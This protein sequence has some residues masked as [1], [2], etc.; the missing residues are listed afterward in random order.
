MAQFNRGD[1]VQHPVFGVGQ[2]RTDEGTTVIIRFQHGIEECVKDDL[3]LIHTPRQALSHSQWHAPFDVITRIQ[4]NA[5]QS[6]NDS[7][8]VFS[9][10]RVALLPHQLWVCR[11]VVETWPTRWMVADDVGL[12]KTIEGGLILSSL[13]ARNIVKRALIIAPASLVT[14]WQIRLRTMFDLRFADYI[15]ASDVPEKEFWDTHNFVV[16]SLE[17]LRLN[18][19]DRWNR[20]L[21]SDPWDLIILDEAHHIGADERNGPT[22][23]YELIQQMVE[24]KRVTSMVFFTGTPHRGK[25]FNFL[26]LMRLLDDRFDPQISFRQQLKYLPSVMIRNNKQNVTDLKGNLLFKPPLVISDTYTYSESEK[27]F[28]QKLTEFIVTG[29]AYASS[30]NPSESQVVILV[31]ITMQKLASSSLAAI[32]RA[33]KGRLGRINDNKG[34]HQILSKQLAEYQKYQEGGDLDEANRLEEELA[35][36]SAQIQ[37]MEDESPRLR[38]LISAAEAVEDET[39][40]KQIIYLVKNRYPDRAILFFTEY[41][42]T[43]SRLMSYLIEQFGENCVTFINGEDRAEDVINSKKQ[44]VVLNEIRET[45]AEKFQSGKVRFL[46]STEAGGEGIDLQENCHTLIH[47]DLPWNPMRLH[48]RV[49]RLNR[50]GQK[51]QVEVL[52]IRNLETV[53]AAIWDKLNSKLGEIKLALNHVMDEPED[54]LQLVLGM[55]SSHLFNEIYSEAASVEQ[56]KLSNWFNQKTAHFGGRDA[57]DTVRDLVGSTSR[58]DFQEIS[59]QL[60]HVDLPNL[61]S[62]FTTMLQLNGRRYREESGEF[63]FKTPENWLD[64]PAIRQNY[65]NMVF[66]REIR[67]KNAAQRILGVGQ[68]VFQKALDQAK[69]SEASL[70][71]LPS[72]ILPTPVFVFRI[73][74]RVTGSGGIVRSVIAA[75]EVEYAE[76]KSFQLLSDWKL[77]LLLNDLI[78][79]KKIKRSEVSFRP[80]NTDEVEKKLNQ[81][82]AEMITQL[83]QLN[84]PFKVPEVEEFAILWPEG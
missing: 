30:L 84:L 67:G 55:T 66:T 54:L 28:Y 53:E 73:Y 13:I 14:Q 81:A 8:G 7:W 71:M 74:D 82:Q 61:V 16:G 57:I 75:L 20:L 38:E 9:L 46:V 22:L 63:S 18:N 36:L 17:T 1:Q 6:I 78:D 39:K 4:A 45:A 21:E 32:L 25:N 31:L 10:S 2:V 27:N 15:S 83:H 26:S 58:F 72:Q 68:K 70:V 42:A 65:E 43:Q 52:T 11:R 34:R 47:V 35:T 56:D 76:G 41:K 48:Q 33:L 51:E 49:G 12:G 62:F 23:G 24:N 5:I 80:E 37:L 79:S 64:G 77:L 60:P 50:Y 59:D 69:Q 40:L 29:K 3:Q 19:K 44:K